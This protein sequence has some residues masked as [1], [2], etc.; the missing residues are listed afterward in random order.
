MLLRTDHF[1]YRV[2]RGPV[3]SGTRSSTVT[4][5]GLASVWAM[6]SA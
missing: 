6:P 1:T 2:R 4:S 5:P 3:G